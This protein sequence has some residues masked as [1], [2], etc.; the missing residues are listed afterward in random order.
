[1]PAVPGSRDETLDE[2][3]AR[4]LVAVQQLREI[5]LQREILLPIP[6]DEGEANN[7]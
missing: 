1:M 4:G 6:S 7:A 3:L 5:L 2:A